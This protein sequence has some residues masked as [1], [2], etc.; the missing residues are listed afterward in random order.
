[1]SVSSRLRPYAWM[2]LPI[3]LGALLYCTAGLV[4]VASLGEGPNASMAA[5]RGAAFAWRSGMLASIVVA[6]LS[7]VVLVKT[8]AGR[9]PV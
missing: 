9:G 5:T 1:M 8:R 2:S 6:S 7:L 3:S 4:M